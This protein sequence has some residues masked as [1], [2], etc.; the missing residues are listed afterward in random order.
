MVTIEKTMKSLL[1]SGALA[2]DILLNYE[3]EFKDGLHTSPS[4]AL[5]VCFRTK[6]HERRF[7]GI[8]ANIAWS[9]NLLGQTSTL[10]ASVGADGSDYLKFLE[11][12]GIGTSDIETLTDVNTAM[13]I[14]AADQKQDQL[15]FFSCGADALGTW[16]GD[17]LMQKK[18]S[19]S[20]AIVCPRTVP[21]VREALD[22]CKKASIPV[23]FDPGQDT[24]A[25]TEEDLLAC[26]QGSYGV[27]LNEYEWGIFSDRFG[28]TQ[29]K[30]LTMATLLIITRAEKGLTMYM[31]D[32][33]MEIAPC[34]PDR[35]GN[36]TGAG[37]G[38]RAGLL[39]GLQYGW[40]LRDAARLGCSLASF[41][42]E[43]DGP[44]VENVTIENIWKRAAAA[45]SEPLPDLSQ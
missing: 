35:I 44:L 26:I 20:Y 4:G 30:V 12:H 21:L 5:S 31:P 7:G 34:P 16:P 18:D 38:F 32:G 17:R 39:T 6:N 23:F 19:F 33:V 22:W 3:G 25:Y 9:L 37:D 42:V 43:Q 8:G 27:I 10:V 28:L 2:Y 41:V 40:S 14:G 45:Y 29:E 15:T 11:K 36:P 13:F 1:V 24:L